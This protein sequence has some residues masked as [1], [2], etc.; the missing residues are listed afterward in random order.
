MWKGG[1]GCAEGVRT[2][3]P[4]ACCCLGWT[5]LRLHRRYLPNYSYFPA[6]GRIWARIPP[7]SAQ[8]FPASLLGWECCVPSPFRACSPLGQAIL[9]HCLPRMRDWTGDA[10]L[11]IHHVF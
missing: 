8:P 7:V 4:A 11:R 10:L 6:A 9:S 5:P 1:L 2:A 3:L